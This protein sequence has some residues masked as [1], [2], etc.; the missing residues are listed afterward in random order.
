MIAAVVG[1]MPAAV[2]ARRAH[3][4]A[5]ELDAVTLDAYGT[6]L[7]LRDP[8]GHLAAQL[9]IRGVE[10]ESQAVERAFR[11]EVEYYVANHLSARD[12]RSLAELRM[13]CADVFLGDLGLELDREEFAPAFAY[14][15]EPLPGAPAAV[16][17][18]ADHGLALAVVANWDVGLYEQLRAH[19]LA[20]YLATVV[21][22][23]EVGAAK[24]DPLPFAVALERLGVRP[25]RV[26]HVGDSGADAEGAAAAGVRFAPAPLATAV[27][28]LL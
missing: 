10:P 20:P 21:T 12:E 17:R 14:E 1:G 22:A 3:G 24:P 19:G 25:E 6:L 28:A 27:A 4:R 18:L 7:R 5:A 2:E 16:A 23:A 8:V 11:A 15:Y 13:R 9:S 26:L